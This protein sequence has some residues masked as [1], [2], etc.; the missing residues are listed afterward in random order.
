MNS[1]QINNSIGRGKVS[2]KVIN[3]ESSSNNLNTFHNIFLENSLEIKQFIKDATEIQKKFWLEFF[4]TKSFNININPHMMKYVFYNKKNVNKIYKYINF[5]FFFE[6]VSLKK[7][8]TDYPP[9]LLI[10]PVSTCN[11]RCPFCFQTDKTFTKKPFMGTMKL[12]LFKNIIDQANELGVGAITIASRGEP[13]LHKDLGQMLKYAKSKENIFEVKLNTNATK[14]TEDLCNQIFE[15]EVNQIVIS[16]DH[17]EKKTFEELRKNSNFETIVK[18][19]KLLFETRKKF[20][21]PLTEIRVSGIDYYKSTNKNIFHDF[22]I[23][24]SDEV[25][26]GNALE[27][28]DTYNNKIHQNINDPCENL[29]DRMYIWF[30]GKVNPCDADYKSYLSY[31]NVNEFSIKKLWNNK[32]IKNIRNKHSTNQRNKIDPCNKCGVTFV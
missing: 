13:T 10:E 2:Q 11:L 21:N 25:T 32:M 6:Q 28:W 18:N 23:K 20:K 17:Y 7:I 22:W 29:W 9:Y 24:I 26:I 15:S 31:G 19:V 8:E 3:L 27:R 1:N 30:D 5:R 12:D 14:L 4:E 16:A